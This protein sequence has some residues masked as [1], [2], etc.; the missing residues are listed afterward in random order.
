MLKL[1]SGSEV[2]K[3]SGALHCK[4][5]LVR[6]PKMMAACSNKNNSVLGI[7]TAPH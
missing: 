2:A 1:N 6:I 7:K 4:D 5:I 3:F